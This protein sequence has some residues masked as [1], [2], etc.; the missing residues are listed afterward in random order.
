M[1]ASC[2]RYV[3]VISNLQSCQ[4]ALIEE[5]VHP[6]LGLG[7]D[8]ASW[9]RGI[10]PIPAQVPRVTVLH[11][12]LDGGRLNRRLQHSEQ[13]HRHHCLRIRHVQV[14]VYGTAGHRL[15]GLRHGSPVSCSIGDF[16]GEHP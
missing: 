13:R 4:E 5:A 11:K 14:E 1:N 16:L 3:I 12:V 7:S 6:E 2:V 9:H 8:S 15:H 10:L